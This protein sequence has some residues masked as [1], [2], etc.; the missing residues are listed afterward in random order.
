MQYIKNNRRSLRF[1]KF[2]AEIGHKQSYKNN[3][4]TM[5]RKWKRWVMSE[6]FNIHWN[7]TFININHLIKTINLLF[8][9]T[10][11]TILLLLQSFLHLQGMMKSERLQRVYA[12]FFPPFALLRTHY[13]TTHITDNI[14]ITVKC[15][16]L[17]CS[18]CETHTILTTGLLHCWVSH[19][20]E[21]RI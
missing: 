14:R 3:I 5:W 17:V 13:N 18:V 19:F 15:N 1:V 21:G 10:T 11:L 20:L 6:R 8:W 2:S 7:N 12:R 4:I 16:I 9:T